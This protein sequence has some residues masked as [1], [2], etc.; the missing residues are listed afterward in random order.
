MKFADRVSRLGTETAFA[1]SAEAATFAARG[2]KVYPFHIG[3]LNFKT[4]AN[5]MDAAIKSMHDGKTGYCP[6]A[7]IPQLREAL[8]E[9]IRST[10]GIACEV[11][12]VAIQPGFLFA[13]VPISGV[14]STGKMTFMYGWH[15]R[16]S[17]R[18]RSK[19][20]LENLNGTS[21]HKF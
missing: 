14:H 16:A 2:N 6:N 8:A 17:I 3:D 15:M 7:G 21:K 5:I 12:N 1:V 9:H 10:R 13:P 11:E 20:V 4:P 18:M 19:K